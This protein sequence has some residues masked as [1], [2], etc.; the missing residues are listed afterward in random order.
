MASSAST[1]NSPASSTHAAENLRAVFVLPVTDATSLQTVLELIQGC[2]GNVAVAHDDSLDISKVVSYDDDDATEVKLIG[3]ACELA[4]IRQINPDVFDFVANHAVACII[5][6]AEH[7]ETITT[8]P[9]F[10]LLPTRTSPGSIWGENAIARIAT[11]SLEIKLNTIFHEAMGASSDRPYSLR[12][13]VVFNCI[14]FIIVNVNRIA[15]M[16]S[17]MTV[18]RVADNS[19]GGGAVKIV[20]GMVDKGH[21]HNCPPSLLSN[22]DAAS[23]KSVFNEWLQN[24]PKRH[25]K[26]RFVW[27]GTTM[28]ASFS[29]PTA[30][31]DG[32]AATTT[33]TP[34]LSETV[35]ILPDD[36]DEATH[37][38]SLELMYRIYR[39]FVENDERHT[40]GMP[41]PD[42]VILTNTLMFDAIVRRHILFSSHSD[43][44]IKRDGD[45]Y[46]TR[47]IAPTTLAAYYHVSAIWLVIVP[48]LVAQSIQTP[49]TRLIGDVEVL[50]RFR[51]VCN[52]CF[53]GKQPR[54]KF[55]SMVSATS[56]LFETINTIILGSLSGRRKTY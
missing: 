53:E 45:G 3:S 38:W 9:A 8:D 41:K 34:R 28:A 20:L 44:G 27:P 22:D 10:T 7:G 37:W 39:F 4:A 26:C 12:N 40:A 16:D 51:E 46:F 13:L 29:P 48:L 47:P 14:R 43:G 49:Q 33:T 21:R 35:M 56:A 24:T 15:K 1:S 30:I 32:C 11:P 19:A 18:A 42:D 23:V 5:G 6:G 50:R 31:D 2:V 54:P 17:I 25:P 36:Y 52:Q 55:E